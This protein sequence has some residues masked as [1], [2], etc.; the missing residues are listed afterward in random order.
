M[1]FKRIQVSIKRSDKCANRFEKL[2]KSLTI[3]TD[4]LAD[5]KGKS[6]FHLLENASYGCSQEQGNNIH[7][8]EQ[9]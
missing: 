3:N 1:Y 7:K 8:I 4:K 5:A 6:F 2:L 9:Q